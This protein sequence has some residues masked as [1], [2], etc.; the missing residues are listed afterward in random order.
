MRRWARL[1]REPLV[2]A[3]KDPL[4]TGLLSRGTSL[5]ASRIVERGTSG[6]ICRLFGES[7]HGLSVWRTEMKAQS[8]DR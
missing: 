7:R 2:L 3:N 4:S 8:V 6:I 1:G 5:T